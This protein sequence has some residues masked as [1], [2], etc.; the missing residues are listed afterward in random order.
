MI[1][2]TISHYKIV[3]KLGE[4][5]MGVVYKAEDTRLDRLVALKFLPH[6]L[7]ASQQEQARFLQEAKAAATLTHANVCVVHAIEE[8]DGQ[9]FIVMEYVEGMTLREKIEA[10]PL[11]LSDAFAYAVHIGEA[12]HEAHSKG[13]VHRDVKAE[14]IMV[15]PKNQVKV[16][17]FGLA[18]LK[19]SLRLTKESSTVGT[20]AYMA[21]EQIQGGEVDARSD[22]FSF[23]V[24]LFE[25][26]TV[27]TPFRGEHDAAM[28]YSILNEEPESIRQHRPEAPA[29][30]DRIVLRS[31]E[32][33]P[34]DRYQHVDDMVSELKLLQKK[35]G[36]V[37]RPSSVDISTAA[38]LSPATNP[39][40][41]KGLM[42]RG[43]RTRWPVIGG[44]AV[45]VLVA[46]GV[47]FSLLTS[48]SDERITSMAV[49]P[50]TN[51][52]T[53][54]NAEYLSDGFTES[55]IN[56]LSKLPGIKMMSRSSVFRYKG[57]EISPQ[58]VAHELGV[59]AVLTGRIIE[60]GN[61]LAISVELISGKDNSHIWGE[62]Y[63]RTMSDIIV[64]QSEISREISSQLKVTLTGDQEAK[65]TKSATENTEAYQL[66]LRGR[67]HWNKRT[68]EGFQK[69]AAYFRQ[70]VER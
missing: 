59:G 69:A 2:R 33:D 22:I 16:M 57:K 53:D 36:R 9:Q 48:R 5:G 54:P 43:S 11:K 26:V 3:E 19:G 31:L 50:F 61:E 70:A 29:D 55:L 52:S 20:L 27:R 13:I 39:D 6:H 14:N 56:S 62:Q 44:I 67:F 4:G 21:P 41:I 10:S 42:Q 34:D 40:T 7:H 47:V 58:T 28:M 35:S 60:R 23:G 38:P 24:V 51:G 12:L 1:G 68:P 63:Y 17:D 30:L 66:Y 15:T 8:S 46:A 65:L 64:L 25:M 45:V 37:T 32:K 18:K 49:L